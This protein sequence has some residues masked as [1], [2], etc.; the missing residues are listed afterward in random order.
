[1]NMKQKA[2]KLSLTITDVKSVKTAIRV[3]NEILESHMSSPPCL[4]DFDPPTPPEGGT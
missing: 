4:Y 1:M 2:S 3:L